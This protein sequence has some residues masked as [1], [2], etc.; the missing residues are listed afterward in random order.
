MAGLIGV[1]VEMWA[2]LIAG[3]IGVV[4]RKVGYLNGRI[5]RCSW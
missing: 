1:V 2:N 3:L 4:G 5:V